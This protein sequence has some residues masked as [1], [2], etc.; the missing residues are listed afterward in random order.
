LFFFFFS[1][2]RRHTRF[3]CDWSSD[4]C[5]SDLVVHIAADEV[6]HARE[7]PQY[8]VRY[9]LLNYLDG[10]TSSPEQLRPVPTAVESSDGRIYFATRGSV[11][12]VDPANIPRNTLPP[13]V[14]I[15]SVTAD[16]K[17][18]NDVDTLRIPAHP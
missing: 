8:Q 7:D 17:V 9:E 15:R 13:P 12:W 14:W 4:V 11:V 10:L 5:S 6:A 16:K 18:Y 1:S 3:D 2:R